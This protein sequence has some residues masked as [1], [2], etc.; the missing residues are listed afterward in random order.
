MC[1]QIIGNERIKNVGKSQSCMVS[2]LPIIWKRTR[3]PVSSYMCTETGRANS[4]ERDDDQEQEEQ[5]EE[6]QKVR[7]KRRRRTRAERGAPAPPSPAAASTAAAPRSPAG[8]AAPAAA[9]PH[10]CRRGWGCA[11]DRR[12]PS[13][14]SYRADRPPAA[15]PLLAPRRPVRCV[16]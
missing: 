3:R 7:G 16:S 12:R 6:G 1:F 9:P 11:P 10:R 4:R 8:P 2:K 5:E 15:P 13:H 14:A